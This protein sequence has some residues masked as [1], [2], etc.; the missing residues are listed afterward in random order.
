MDS[1]NWS[2][3]EFQIEKPKMRITVYINSIQNR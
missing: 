1:V 3:E 2:V